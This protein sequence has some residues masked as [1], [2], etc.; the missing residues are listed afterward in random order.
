MIDEPTF[1]TRNEAV[2]AAERAF[3]PADLTWELTMPEVSWDAQS[4]LITHAGALP[5]TL[6]FGR[7][8]LDLSKGEVRFIDEDH[9][10]GGDLVVHRAPLPEAWLTRLR[11][12]ER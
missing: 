11:T 4:Q 8:E 12:L 3:I 7:M 6:H 10:D 2:L 5:T 9:R 1:T